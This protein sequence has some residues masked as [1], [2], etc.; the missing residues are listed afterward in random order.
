MK[1]PDE[2]EVRVLLAIVA[3]GF[4]VGF[5]ILVWAIVSGQM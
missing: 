3:G 4:A 1:D 5:A 2:P